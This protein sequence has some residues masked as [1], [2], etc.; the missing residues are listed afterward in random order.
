LLSSRI[1]D[2]LQ[3]DRPRVIRSSGDRMPSVKN[4]T[5]VAI[6]LYIILVIPFEFCIG[7][8]ILI[9]KHWELLGAVH[10]IGVLWIWFWNRKLRTKS[11]QVQAATSAAYFLVY[12]IIHWPWHLSNPLSSLW[13][14]MFF[15]VVSLLTSLVLRWDQRSLG[16]THSNRAL[17][18][19]SA[20][21]DATA[22]R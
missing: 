10:L 5:M 2:H 20:S 1:R 13:R 22:N 14:I 3:T 19:P 6:V 21:A 11:L 18:V 17:Q 8:Y 15:A 7:D 9:L 12:E 16:K 4:S